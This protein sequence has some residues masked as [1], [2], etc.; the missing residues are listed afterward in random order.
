MNPKGPASSHLNTGTLRFP[1]V[2]QMLRLFQKSELLLRASR[3]TPQNKIHQNGTPCSEIPQIICTNYAIF[4]YQRISVKQL[5]LAVVHE[6]YH[7]IAISKFVR[8]HPG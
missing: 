1:V 6:T 8:E 3:A 2:K 5:V 7:L 4:L